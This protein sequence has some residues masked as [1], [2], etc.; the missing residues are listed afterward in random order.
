MRMVIHCKLVRN[1]NDYGDVI[2]VANQGDGCCL[3]V[4]YKYFLFNRG[5]VES[6]IT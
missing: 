5:G 3:E 4:R 1:R 2:L 6:K